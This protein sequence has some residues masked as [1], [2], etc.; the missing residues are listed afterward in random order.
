MILPSLRRRRR[1]WSDR[2][3]DLFHGRAGRV[4]GFF[5]KR[6]ELRLGVFCGLFGFVLQLLELRLRLFRELLPFLD[7]LIGSFLR[8]FRDALAGVLR[9]LFEVVTR[10]FVAAR[11]RDQCYDHRRQGNYLFHKMLLF[12]EEC[13]VA[14]SDSKL[15]PSDRHPPING[16]IPPACGSSAALQQSTSGLH[17]ERTSRARNLQIGHTLDAL[18]GA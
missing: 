2:L 8:V 1:G 10:L 11:E 12:R 6:L 18:A 5:A 14:A 15:L 17:Y 9:L 4:L 16:S 7:P 3:F 13:L